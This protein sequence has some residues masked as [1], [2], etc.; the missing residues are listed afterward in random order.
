M[1]CLAPTQAGA[2]STA[3]W[4]PAVRHAGRDDGVLG[5]PRQPTA[6]MAVLPCH[7]DMLWGTATRT[8]ESVR[9][10]GVQNVTLI[11]NVHLGVTL[12]EVHHTSSSM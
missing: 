6:R 9:C 10:F 12:I 1:E 2:A 3:D 5:C 8:I 4:T 11:Y 7:D